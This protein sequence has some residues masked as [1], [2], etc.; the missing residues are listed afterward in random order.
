[1][2]RL[3]R[4]VA[5]LLGVTAAWRSRR[6]RR[7]GVASPAAVRL[8]HLRERRPGRSL[9][10]RGAVAL[11]VL[12]VLAVVG[13][14][15]ALGFIYSGVYDVAATRQHT[16]PVYWALITTLRQSVLARASREVGPVPDLSAPHYA[17]RG[18]A[19]YDRNCVPCHGAPGVAMH[20]IGMGLTPAPSN[21]VMTARKW[22]SHEIFWAVKNGFKMTGMPAWRFRLTDEEIWSVVAFVKT[23]PRMTPVEYRTRR[24]AL[25]PAREPAEVSP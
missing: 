1:V 8:S 10:R 15:G 9:L 25:V 5:L 22:E 21:L 4:T 20:A 18:L 23:M 13:A 17:E 3:W 24:A 11:G 16:P 7:P 6:A 2:K 12:V 14:L 19:I